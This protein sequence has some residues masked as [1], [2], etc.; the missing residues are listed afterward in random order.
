[1]ILAIRNNLG[2]DSYESFKQAIDIDLLDQ[3]PFDQG[4][5][6]S[7]LQIHDPKRK[8][9]IFDLAAGIFPSKEDLPE[10]HRQPDQNHKSGWTFP[11][12]K[13]NRR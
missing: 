6:R 9:L 12:L 1:M 13:K 4:V 10:L 11:F 2:Y 5:R 7:N 3:M 8:Q